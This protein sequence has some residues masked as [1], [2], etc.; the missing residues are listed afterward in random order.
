M[1]IILH[2][3]G[4][5]RAPYTDSLRGLLIGSEQITALRLAIMYTLRIFIVSPNNLSTNQIARLFLFVNQSKIKHQY[6]TVYYY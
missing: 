4:G 5:V 3:S 1:N 6:I 2:T